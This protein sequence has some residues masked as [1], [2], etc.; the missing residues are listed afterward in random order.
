LV[1]DFVEI[2]IL[3]LT[4]IYGTGEKYYSCANQ[5]TKNIKSVISEATI[6]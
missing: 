1:A 6:P 2:G 5:A 4:N 3:I